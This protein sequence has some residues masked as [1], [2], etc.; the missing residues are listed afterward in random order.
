MVLIVR[1]GVSG[2]FFPEFFLQQQTAGTSNS[3]SPSYNRLL[4]LLIWSKTHGKSGI[5]SSV[6]PS[7][8]FGR[9]FVHDPQRW[10]CPKISSLLLAS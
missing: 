7:P 1:P 9:L 6:H 2:D 10:G 5:L 8:F 4:L 3:N